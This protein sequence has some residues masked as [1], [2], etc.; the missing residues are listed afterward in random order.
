MGQ[1][2]KMGRGTGEAQA[3]TTK[4]ADGG[5][6]NSHPGRQLRVG[7]AGIVERTELDSK[8]LGGME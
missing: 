5:G 8:G 7:R 4:A 2:G 3:S 1:D 6:A